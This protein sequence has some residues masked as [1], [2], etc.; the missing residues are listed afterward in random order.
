MLSARLGAPVDFSADPM[1]AVG[2]GAAIYA[3]TMERTNRAGPP[4][5][6][7]TSGSADRIHL[8]LAYEPV[9]AELECVVA[10]RVLNTDREV[11]IK[12]EAE[13][14]HWTSGWMRPRGGIFES[15]VSLKE[16]EITTVWVYAR[17]LQGRLLE[18]DNSEFKVRHGLVL[19]ATPLP[20][21]LSI[22]LLKSGGKPELDAVFKKGTP[23]PAE[24]R[25]KYRAT[26]AVIPDNPASDLAI[27]L[28]EGEFLEDPDANE[29]VGHA[30]LSHS[31]VRRTIPVGTEIEITIKIDTSRLIKIEAFVSHLNQH[32]SYSVY[33]A[34]REEQDFSDL[35]QA[36]ASETQ[37]FRA[38]VDALERGAAAGQDQSTRSELEEIRRDVEELHSKS[39]TQDRSPGTSD[40]DD[41][42]RI[43]EESKTLRGRLG[44][45]ERRTSD[46]RGSLETTKFLALVEIGQEVVQN[47]GSSLEK[48]QLAL[49]L[50]ELERSTIKK[51]D[52][53]VQRICEEI[54]GLRWRVLGKQEWFWK[55]IFDSLRASGTR[56][57]D[58]N[59]ARSLIAKGQSALASG[60]GEGLRAV[61]RSLWKLQPPSIAET[62]RD[63]AMR[64][65]LRMY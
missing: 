14:G 53:A 47:F 41:N 8:K 32:F 23:L 24:R 21:T 9:S 5:P 26:H 19:A 39:S 4:G 58:T 22:E 33:V 43:V 36:V 44:R 2:R 35:A 63:R 34:Q 62:A 61:V 52:K 57:M 29:W 56:F 55:E 30:L 11:E 27:K 31:E 38:R 13:G 65:G 10:G 20:H 40:P 54:D 45:L 50:R 3:S 18:T 51:D 37:A 48:Q 46:D 59:E 6:S 12:F 42:R 60:D 17:D 64:S 7:I 49:L 15:N 28:W 16:G 25:V 1:T